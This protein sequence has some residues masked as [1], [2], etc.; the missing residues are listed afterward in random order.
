MKRREPMAVGDIIRQAIE[1]YG[2]TDDFNRQR[3]CS[4]W[5]EIVGPSINRMTTRRWVD[6]DTLHVVIASAAVKNEL[7]FMRSRLVELLN[8]AAGKETISSIIIH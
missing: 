8:Q 2:A 1:S 5:P 7:L 4:L 6:H 3:V